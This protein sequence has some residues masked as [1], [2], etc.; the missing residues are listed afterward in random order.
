MKSV[1][2]RFEEYLAGVLLAAIAL[3]ICVQLV[4]SVAA[5]RWAS[6][7][8]TLY[9]ALFFW[10]TMLGIPAA[11]RRR[12]HL[13]LVFLRRHVPRRWLRWLH[14]LWGVAAVAF[15]AT[16]AVTGTKLVLDVAGWG[17]RF[18]GSSFPDWVVTLG[19]PVAAALSVVRALQAVWTRGDEADDAVEG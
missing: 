8:T 7:L 4:L 1:L 14:A 9:L 5:P 11:T 12:A 13:S 17:D 19:L 6:P 10:A 2:G 15:F 3:I 16:L 18:V